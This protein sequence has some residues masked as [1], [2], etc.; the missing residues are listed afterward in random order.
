MEP[1]NFFPTE[2]LAISQ[3]QSQKLS[4]K[5]L[6][7]VENINTLIRKLLEKLQN[8]EAGFVITTFDSSGQLIQETTELN[9][10]D[11]ATYDAEKLFGIDLNND[12][13]QG[14][15][16]TQLDE[17][18]EIR[19]YQF[20]TF[21]DTTNLTDLYADVNSGDIFFCCSRRHKLC[22]TFRLRRL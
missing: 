22:R 20:N 11:A 12:N 15:N 4:A 19:R 18:S 14:R 21:D 16:V 13:H 3:K 2:K 5:E 10:A 1:Y 17:L 6:R 8:F 9:P 7:S